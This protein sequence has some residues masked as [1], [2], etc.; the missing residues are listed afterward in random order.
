MAKRKGESRKQTAR[1][2]G[3]YVVLELTG[4]GEYKVWL[5]GIANTG[6]G[7][8]A[9]RDRGQGGQVLRVAKFTTPPMRVTTETV[10]KTLLTEEAEDV[11]GGGTDESAAAT[12]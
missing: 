8:N 11:P 1:R 9:I 4:W 10:Q 2:K 7:M 3:V 12:D 5:P 6:D